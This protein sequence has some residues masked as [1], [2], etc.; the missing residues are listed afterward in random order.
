MDTFL[1]I[2][3]HPKNKQCNCISPFFLADLQGINPNTERNYTEDERKLIRASVLRMSNA[4]GCAIN[5]CCDPEADYKNINSKFLN[6]VLYKFSHY[7]LINKNGILDS[8]NLWDKQNTNTIP[9]STWKIIKP[10]IICKISKAEIKD[11]DINHIKIAT[12]LVNDCFIN[13]CDNTEIIQLKNIISGS[14]VDMNATYIDDMKVVNA[15]KDGDIVYLKEY[16][17]LYGV[18]DHPLTYDNEN[19]RMIHLISQYGTPA[20]M[21]LILALK[22]NLDIINVDGNTALHLASLHGKYD[23]TEKLLN[24]GSMPNTPNINNEFPINMAIRSGNFGL[25]RLLYSTGAGLMYY[26]NNGNN[27]LHYTILYAPENDDKFNIIQ[28]LINHGLNTEENNKQNKTPLQLTKYKIDKINK[29]EYLTKYLTNNTQTKLLDKKKIY[30]AVNDDDY[31]KFTDNKPTLNQSSSWWSNITS[32]FSDDKI[33]PITTSLNNN[34]SNNHNNYNN[35]EV[36]I[37]VKY[38]KNDGLLV[39]N[40]DPEILYINKQNSDIQPLSIELRNLLQIQTLLFNNIIANNPEKYKDK[41]FNI[42]DMPKGANIEGIYNQ[43]VGEN[44]RG[45]EDSEECKARGGRMAQVKNATTRIKID[46]IDV[47]NMSKIEAIKDSDLMIPKYKIPNAN[48]YNIPSENYKMDIMENMTHIDK[49]VNHPPIIDD[50][51]IIKYENDAQKNSKKLKNIKEGFEN[52]INNSKIIFGI[53][54][55]IIIIFLLFVLRKYIDNHYLE[56]YVF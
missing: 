49:D 19:N 20:M 45:D 48:E 56:R 27:L 43:C 35:K 26:D 12:K 53:I 30:F 34:K 8:I 22:P 13:N 18:I 37:P 40:N 7:Q 54:I 1:K 21:D 39:E 55:S 14:S 16:I 11:S 5:S 28:F 24:Q 23:N 3:S 51:N 38:D 29:S 10:Y 2:S 31:E 6:D 4:R 52:N 32:Y 25:I 50:I 17:K 42:N 36:K 15:I 47:N 46:M 9:D 33:E 44:I 41:Y